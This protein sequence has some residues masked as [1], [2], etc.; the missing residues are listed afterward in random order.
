MT[1]RSVHPLGRSLLA[2][3]ALNPEAQQSLPPMQN[4]YP[5][6]R[7]KVFIDSNRLLGMVDC[8]FATCA[9]LTT[10]LQESSMPLLKE[11]RAWSQ[12]RA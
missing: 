11:C 10:K 5:L 12:A 9:L 7:S 1:S 8:S 4:N 2:A 6:F 3:N